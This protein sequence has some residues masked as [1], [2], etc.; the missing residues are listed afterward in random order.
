MKMRTRLIRG[1][2]AL[3]GIL[4][5]AA[6]AAYAGT[7]HAGKVTKVA[8]ATPAKTSDYGWNQQGVNSAKAAAAASGATL[9]VITNIGY[10]K[11]PVVLRQLA[12]SGA[13]FIIAHAS[14]YDTDR[15]SVV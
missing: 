15:K 11:T 8:I 13:N 14:G 1:T 9:Q 7:L 10:D 2:A 4:A 12:K 6:G 3:G 5:L